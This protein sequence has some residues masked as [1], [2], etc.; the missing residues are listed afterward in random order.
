MQVKPSPALCCATL[1][2]YPISGFVSFLLYGPRPYNPSALSCGLLGGSPLHAH[3]P[4]RPWFDVSSFTLHTCS[5]SPFYLLPPSLNYSRNPSIWVS[6]R[7][8]TRVTLASFVPSAV[9]SSTAQP[10]ASHPRSAIIQRRPPDSASSPTTCCAWFWVAVES[11]SPANATPTC[12]PPPKK[13]AAAGQICLGRLD[14]TY[15]V[16]PCTRSDFRHLIANHN[17]PRIKAR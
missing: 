1:I 17:G 13:R 5:H 15:T 11:S 3:P 12:R 16:Y 14:L 4:L 7:R 10:L 8:H 2:P 6:H 9:T